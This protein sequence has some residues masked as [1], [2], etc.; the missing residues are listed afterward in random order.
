MCA[1]QNRASCWAWIN[2]DLLQQTSFIL[3]CHSTDRERNLKSWTSSFSRGRDCL[4]CHSFSLWTVDINLPVSDSNYFIINFDLFS[5]FR[6]FLIVHLL[7]SHQLWQTS[8]VTW[9]ALSFFFLIY[10]KQLPLVLQLYTC[11]ASG[12]CNNWNQNQI[13]L[14]PS[15]WKQTKDF[16]SGFCSFIYI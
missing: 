13:F 10:V 15:L 11:T 7:L 3:K 14:G 8:N 1:D 2:H 6:I 9:S 4:W 12:K 5:Q 16:D